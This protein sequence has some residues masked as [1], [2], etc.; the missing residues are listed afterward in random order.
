[1]PHL[2]K[3][4][5]LSFL[6]HAYYAALTLLANSSLVDYL[7]VRGAH[8]TISLDQ[9]VASGYRVLGAIASSLAAVFP[10][11]L[12]LISQVAVWLMPIL[13]L[14]G[15]ILTLS[16]ISVGI[17]LFLRAFTRKVPA[18]VIVAICTLT[19]V[20]MVDAYRL[21]SRTVYAFSQ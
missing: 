13:W 12:G 20:L 11:L 3:L 17:L 14:V 10:F 2:T 15:M 9:L 18:F 5:T 8:R 7:A 1:M 4:S 19:G 21:L 16:D 6:L